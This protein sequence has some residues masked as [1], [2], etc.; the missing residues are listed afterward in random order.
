VNVGKSAAKP[1]LLHVCESAINFYSLRLNLRYTFVYYE[2]LFIA[3]VKKF[4]W[5]LSKLPV[6][7]CLVRRVP[8][9]KEFRRKKRLTF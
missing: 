2:W 4:S 1:D 3:Y 9:R 7:L 5:L 8:H 6:V